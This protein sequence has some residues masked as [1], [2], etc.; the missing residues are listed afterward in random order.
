MSDG[1]LQSEILYIAPSPPSSH[2][3]PQV[4]PIAAALLG[5][6]SYGITLVLRAQEEESSYIPLPTSRRHSSPSNRRRL[7][8]T[9][10]VPLRQEQ[11]GLIASVVLVRP[12]PGAEG[13][14]NL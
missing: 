3:R 7:T 5:S 14:D 13:I 12:L 10:S 11:L 4:D 9:S 8:L 6:S 2:P 1:I